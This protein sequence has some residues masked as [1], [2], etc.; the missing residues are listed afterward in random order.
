MD[1][2]ELTGIRRASSPKTCLMARVSVRSFIG[3]PVPW[4]L[5]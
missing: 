2:V 4:A 3:V 5:T 1:L